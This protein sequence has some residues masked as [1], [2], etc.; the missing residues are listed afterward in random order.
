MWSL[1]PLPPGR[2]TVQYK[3]VFKLKIKFDGSIDRYKAR[4]VMK[5]FSQHLGLDYDETYAHVAKFHHNLFAQFSILSLPK[6]CIFF[7][8]T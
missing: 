8:L 6:T 1:V 5:G 3:W 7:N 2:N 4:L